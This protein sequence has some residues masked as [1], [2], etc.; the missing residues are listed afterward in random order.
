MTKKY[1]LCIGVGIY[2]IALISNQLAL[3]LLAYFCLG[4]DVLKKTIQ[5]LGKKDFFDEN[6]L[7]TIATLGA[8]I[9]K[10]YKEAVAVMLFYQIGES[11]SDLAVDRSRD[12]IVSLM[13]LRSEKTRLLVQGKEVL[14]VTSS[15]K[16][17]SIISVYPGEKIPLDGEVV[18]GQSDL[19]MQSL[20]GE[21][22]PR[23]V[24]EKDV[25]LSGSVVLNKPLHIKVTTT[26]QTST[27][28]KILELVEKVSENKTETER[29]ITRFS[30]IYTPVVCLL[31][32]L[33]FLIPTLFFGQEASLW[34]YRAL[35]F[36]VISCPCALVLS[37]PLSFFCGIGRATKEGI[38]VKSTSTLE[39]L[40]MIRTILFDKTGTLTEG[41][42]TVDKVICAENVK[43][44]E[45]LS[46]ALAAEMFSNHPISFALQQK[47]GIAIHKKEITQLEEV[48]GQG[49]TCYYQ[50]KPLLVGNE[51]L[52]ANHNISFTQQQEIGTIIHVAYDNRYQGT[53]IFQDN[54]KKDSEKAIQQ[55][56]DLGLKT[57]MLTGDNKAVAAVIAKKLKMAYEAELLPV[58]KVEAVCN[59]QKNRDLVAFV[60]DGINDAP[61]LVKS[62]I[63]ISMGGVGSDAAIE[64]SDIILMHDNILSLV[65][66]YQ[67]S[68]YTTKKVKQNIVFSLL[69]KIIILFLGSLGYVS[70][71]LAV[72]ADVGVTLLAVLNSLLILRKKV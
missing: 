25:V 7:M 6:F 32:L 59:Y 34:F 15:V 37:V 60:G 64:A 16:I 39:K 1:Q 38:I 69:V 53:I 21:S 5:S 66:A 55:L 35:L 49:I 13:D 11:L 29:F 71:W 9:I 10:D 18:N 58:N 43:E 2:I 12:K 45:V 65:S 3:Y 48:A 70:I 19:D 61:A 20:T 63:G 44:K 40:G 36:L 33:L 51:T 57:V 22:L 17:G 68:K 8:F 41:K 52:L 47:K 54:V 28:T 31:A 56:H 4:Y 42:L 23:T 26:M 46:L 27:V 72:F 62:D 67:I 30:K 14:V 50:N 24:K